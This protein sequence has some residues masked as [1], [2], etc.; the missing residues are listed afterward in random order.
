MILQCEQYLLIVIT[1]RFLH[2]KYTKKKDLTIETN[3]KRKTY[4]IAVALETRKQFLE[5]YK[6]W[7]LILKRK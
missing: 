5:Y 4:K 7:S 6:E 1:K 3:K 2:W